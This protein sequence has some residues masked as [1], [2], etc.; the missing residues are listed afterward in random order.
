MNIEYLRLM[1]N[2]PRLYIS[3]NRGVKE[4]D[5]INFEQK[6]NKN[7]PKAYKEFLFLGGDGANMITSDQGFYNADG[8]DKIYI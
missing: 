2:T 3:D 8:S 6:L 1:K 4:Q 5:I 7:L